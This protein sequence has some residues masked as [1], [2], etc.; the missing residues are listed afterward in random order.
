[1]ILMTVLLS[2]SVPGTH[3]HFGRCAPP[4]G[5][6]GFLECAG[7]MHEPGIMGDDH[8]RIAHDLLDAPFAH[9]AMAPKDLEAGAGT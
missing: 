6:N 5:E 7:D 2:V 4:D 9:I 3:A 8:A 1:M